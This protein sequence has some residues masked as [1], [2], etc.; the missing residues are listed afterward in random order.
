MSMR[1]RAMLV[2]PRL[3]LWG[4][5]KRKPKMA[6]ETAERHG[7]QRGTV[8]TDVLLVPDWALKPVRSARTTA[9]S[10]HERMTVPWFTNGTGMLPSELYFE[11]VKGL[12]KVRDEQF[13][14]AVEDLALSLDTLKLEGQAR[15]GNAY[16]ERDWPV[17]ADDLRSRF[18]FDVIFTPLPD[19]GDI[20]LNI[21]AEELSEVRRV[22]EER[23][24]AQYK[25]ATRELW[26][27]VQATVE[28]SLSSLKAYGETGE[29]RKRMRTFR[30]SVVDNLRSQVEWCRKLNLSADTEL[31]TYLAKVE[32]DLCF[33]EPE[34]LRKHESIRDDVV[35]KAETILA[36]M[37]AYTGAE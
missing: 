12:N 32:H 18:S 34:D 23:I 33:Y 24:N 3:T 9:L 6:T 25:A 14:P 20:R 4:A 8:R 22:T 17:S 31:E 29:N 36:G 1:D 30:D 19:A 7:M 2:Q 5:T 27:R 15:F 10:L 13:L 26:Q 35:Q 21:E 11:Y 16:D 28:A 37:S